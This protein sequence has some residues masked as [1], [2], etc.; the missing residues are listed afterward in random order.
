MHA[1]IVDGIDDQRD[2]VVKVATLRKGT[3]VRIVKVLK[4]EFEL[5]DFETYEEFPLVELRNPLTGEL[6]LAR[7][8]FYFLKDLAPPDN[9]KLRVQ[10]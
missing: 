1:Y 8:S 3:K 7:V 5:G 10:K 2:C 6:V 4:E 9:S